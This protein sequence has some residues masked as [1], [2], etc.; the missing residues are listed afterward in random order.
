MGLH[1]FKSGRGIFGRAGALYGKR[2]R[3]SQLHIGQNHQPLQTARFCISVKRNL[4]RTG[5]RM[6]LRPARSRLKKEYSGG[7]VERDDAAS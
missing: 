4:R 5:G 6:G 1:L 2:K 3:Q 7:M